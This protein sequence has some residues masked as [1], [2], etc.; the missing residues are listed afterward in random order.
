[1]SFLEF[2]G[3]SVIGLWLFASALIWVDKQWCRL[4]QRATD[5]TTGA[6]IVDYLKQRYLVN[7][8][9]AERHVTKPP[10]ERGEYKKGEIK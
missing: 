4:T 9:F 5:G 10:R 3:F 6:S 1:M 7:A 8:I 2:V